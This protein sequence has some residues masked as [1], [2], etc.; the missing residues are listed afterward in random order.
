MQTINCDT[1]IILCSY[2]QL[3]DKDKKLVDA[4]KMAATRA[5]APYSGFRVGAAL[6]CN[7]KTVTGNNQENAS[8]PCGICAERVALFAAASQNPGG[9]IET[10][11]IAAHNGR[12]F[13]NDAVTPC[14]SCRQVMLEYE[15]RQK[16]PIRI[17][18]HGEER[19]FIVP[20]AASLL[21]LSFTLPSEK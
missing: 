17:I 15:M 13:A 16:S 21:P 19:T 2:Q 12:E 3:D 4:A 10:I 7:G 5:Y 11:A 18:M 14:G 20:S 9:A 8:Y 1:K 6:L